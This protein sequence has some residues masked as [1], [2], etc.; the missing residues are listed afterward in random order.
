M[1]VKTGSKESNWAWDKPVK[2]FICRS[3]RMSRPIGWLP[4]CF[5][6]GQLTLSLIAEQLYCRL[7]PA[8][9]HFL[10]TLWHAH[11]RCTVW[12]GAR[13][14]HRL[15]HL[16]AAWPATNH[17]VLQPACCRATDSSRGRAVATRAGFL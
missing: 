5:F 12:Y 10:E 7:R 14:P 8:D 2:A 9:W 17:G 6:G 11:A 4:P 1:S 3:S 15:P 16:A 13:I